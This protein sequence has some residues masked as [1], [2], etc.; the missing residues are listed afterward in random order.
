VWFVAALRL[1]VLL[2]VALRSGVPEHYVAE[3]RG[4]KIQV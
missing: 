2:I 1:F 4:K 3:L